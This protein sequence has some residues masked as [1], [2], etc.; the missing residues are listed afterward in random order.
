[1]QQAK[2]VGS[3]DPADK[4]AVSEP[5][6]AESQ[7]VAPGRAGVWRDTCRS[8]EKLMQRC[9]WEHQAPADTSGLRDK[10]CLKNCL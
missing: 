10:Y 3:P 6:A 7:S 1:M 2:G 4:E 9:F 8:P 5:L